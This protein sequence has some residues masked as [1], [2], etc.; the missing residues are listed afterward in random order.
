MNQE[1]KPFYGNPEFNDVLHRYQEMLQTGKQ[2]FFDVY[3]FE[4]LIEHFL[5]TGDISN[6]SSVIETGTIQ[7]PGSNNL[8]LRKV[9]LLIDQGKYSDAIEIL[10]VVENYE[11]CNY[12]LYLLKG[13][14]S[15]FTGKHT[16]ARVYFAKA[17]EMSDENRID[18]L[19]SI[20]ANYENL[21]D[22][23]TALG[24]LEKAHKEDYN[25]LSVLFE[26]AYC[27][28]RLDDFSNAVKFYN[29][30]LDIDPFS[31]ITWF[32][33]GI[34]FSKTNDFDK[35]VEAF[36]FVITLNEKY[37]LAYFNKGNALVNSNKYEEAIKA[38]TE[39][40]PFEEN[41]AETFCF[42]GE[43][44]ER[45][46]KSQ[47]ALDYYYKSLSA[48]PNYSDAIYG[49]GIIHSIHENFT[50]SIEYILKAIAIDPNSSDYWFS[51]GSIYSKMKFHDKAI[52]AYRRSTFL[53]PY[54]YESWLNLSEIFYTR[55]L[56]SK[57]IKT[58]EEAYS[59]NSN[60]ALVNYRLAAFNLL[61]Q[62][63][64]EGLM[65]FQKGIR[66][67]FDD[68]SDIFKFYPEASEIKE[69]WELIKQ[70][71]HIKQ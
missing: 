68:H 67:N 51:L 36:D 66:Y 16:E 13:I 63:K 19:F 71:N 47:Q 18:T 26:L 40:L 49:I 5:Q 8:K 25:N 27:H 24:Y 30:F 45:L 39:Y 58:L 2:V 10:N 38:Y 21:N 4:V 29:N 70:F 11:K 17:L 42:I 59:Y 69:I 57:A 64:S 31:E 46:G 6:A 48:D 53:D 22:F 50:V 14:A 1:N 37:P 41:K 34:V 55:N 61:R 20:A 35:A 23:N 43:C 12:E 32:N 54:D 3:E 33:L 60:V 7:H 65:Y 9:Q 44:Y 15:N 56:L 52:E 28:D 62:N